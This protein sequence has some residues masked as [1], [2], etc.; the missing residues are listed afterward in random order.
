MRSAPDRSPDLRRWS[1]AGLLALALLFVLSGAA[2]AQ[3]FNAWLT[4]SGP[5]SGYIEIPSAAD[6]NPTSA[7]TI[8]AWVNLSDADGC[9]SI[10]GKNWQQ[11]WWLG[12]CGTTFRTY[13]KGG[14][15]SQVNG[16]VIPHGEWTHVAVVYDGSTRKHYIN[17][18]L[19][20]T[21]PET[22]TLPASGDPVRIG[23]DVQWAHTPVGAIDEVRIWNVARTQDQ[24]RASIN[25]ASPTPTTGLVARWSLDGTT[26]D[27][28]P[29]HHNGSIVGSG[30]NFFTSAVTLAPCSQTATSL[31]F[32]NRYVVTAKFRV[33]APGTAEGTGQTVGCANSGSGLF[34]FFD[35][36]NWELM[37]KAINACGLNN[38]YWIFSAATT[39]VFYRMEVFDLHSG[40]NKVYFNYPGP[41]A[42]A[43]TD[44]DALATC[45]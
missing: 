25:I 15:P 14:L 5:T 1:P 30:I 28:T 7:I 32:F 43:V 13:L 2:Q 40:V 18:E 3:P 41:P 39:N 10:V 37:V 45:P 31:C 42:P 26:N 8:E 11:A 19:V 21:H 29:N 44:T 23:S 27:A 17:G 4:L 12:I 34:W 20:V 9:S 16:G 22:G 36:N 6:L 38:R 24:I 33:G 35:S